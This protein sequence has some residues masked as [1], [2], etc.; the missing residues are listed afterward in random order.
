MKIRLTQFSIDLDYT[1]ESL[2]RAVEAKL[3]VGDADLLSCT[4][5]R[6]SIDARARRGP[7]QFTLRID[8]E[9]ADE[10]DSNAWRKT[11]DVEIVSN[12]DSPSPTPAAIQTAPSHPPLAD[13]PVVVGAGPAGL[14]AA[15]RLA[16]SGLAPILI[17]RGAPA[18]ERHR[19]VAKFWSQ[20]QLD[21]DDNVLFGEGGA[22]LYSDGKLTTQSKLRGPMRTV[23]QL[24]VQCGADESILIDA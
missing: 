13:P 2:R 24:L 9:L 12:F 6:R 17:E 15:W 20:G 16:M 18:E 14:L 21:A 7:V 22:G 1:D 5:T 3:G 11:P 10:F 4:V 8:V 23:L 19:S